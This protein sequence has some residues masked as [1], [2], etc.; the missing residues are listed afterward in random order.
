MMNY[1]VIQRMRMIDFLLFH[2]GQIGR[3]VIMDY[4]GIGEAAATRDFTAYK[5]LAP[6]NVEYSGT[7][8][9]YKRTLKF[10]RVYS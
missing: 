6:D 4:F 3:K 5:E 8:K 2:Y 10:E 7:D 9:V 1:A